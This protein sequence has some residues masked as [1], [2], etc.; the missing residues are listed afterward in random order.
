MSGRYASGRARRRHSRHVRGTGTRIRRLTATSYAAV[1]TVGVAALGAADLLPAGVSS[2]ASAAAGEAAGPV[3]T[4]RI[5]AP[6]EPSSTAPTRYAPAGGY[7][8]TPPAVE[9]ELRQSLDQKPLASAAGPAESGTGKRVVFDITGQQVWLV[10]ADGTVA[11]T[12]LVSGSQHDQLD[13]G[14]Y[15]VFSTSRNTVS[16]RYTET[17]EYMVRFHRGRNSNIGFHDIPVSRTTGEEVQT[18]AELGTPLSDGCIRQDHDDAKALYEF[19]PVGTVVVV[20]RT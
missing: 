9:V 8:V 19:A 2:S 5:A 17:M 16:W 13:P 4:S 3:H 6:D 20:V 1:A 18:L 7:D 15:D 11:R 12:Y 14:S 10:A